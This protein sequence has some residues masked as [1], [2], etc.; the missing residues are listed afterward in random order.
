MYHEM[1]HK[2]DFDTCRLDS[3]GELNLTTCSSLINFGGDGQYKVS[4]ED[5]HI[6]C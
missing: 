6:I 2:L 3:N 1:D 5:P 4:C